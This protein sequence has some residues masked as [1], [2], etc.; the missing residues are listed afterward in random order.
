M[1]KKAK[2]P[3]EDAALVFTPFAHA[4][5]V[6]LSNRLWRKQ[7]IP[8]GDFDYKGG[9]LSFTKAYLKDLAQSFKDKVFPGVPFQLAGADNKHTNAVA[10]TV[11][12]VRDVELGDDG[13]YVIIEA[14]EDGEKVLK[15]YPELGV[16]ARIY[17]NYTRSDGR[18]WPAALQ[19]VLGTWDPHL[20][21]M[22]GW[23]AVSL[24]NDGDDVD[25]VDLTEIDITRKEGPVALTDDDKKQLSELLKKV[26]DGGSGISDDD[27]DSLIDSAAGGDEGDDEGELS[28]EE[29]AQLL[30]DAGVDL[31][32]EGE[33]EPEEE[34]QRQTVSASNKGHRRELDLANAQLA[35][36]REELSR[37]TGQLDEQA[38][39]NEKGKYVRDLGLPPT[40]IEMARPLLEGTG[41]VIELAGGDEVDAGRVMRNVLDEIGRCVKVL[42]LGHLVGSGEVPP[43]A[44]EA[45]RLEQEAKE[46]DAFVKG[47]RARMG[48]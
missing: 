21:G 8:V 29:L 38:F 44:E 2:A 25:V 28:D 1:G 12:K 3:P 27:L 26:R 22:K 37:I 23:E 9:K 45:E 48:Y 31:E 6:E 35:Q 36:Q 19:H 41:H 46:R 32:E 40:A 43:D 30:K 13:L 34:G 20:P 18:H 17:E 24:S 11:G 10:N 16:S 7:L 39:T 42:D 5:T 4:A 33:E 47:E 14:S 15:Q